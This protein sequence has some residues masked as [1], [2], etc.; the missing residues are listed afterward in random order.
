M[1]TTTTTRRTR[2]AAAA[3][4]VKANVNATGFIPSSAKLAG[5]LNALKPF[6]DKQGNIPDLASIRIE[7]DGETKKITLAACDR[8]V[9]GEYT[10]DYEGGSFTADVHSSNVATLVTFLKTPWH[11]QP[12]VVHYEPDADKDKPGRLV[13]AID[14]DSVSVPTEA[15]VNFPQW[16]ALYPD[17]KAQ[18]LEGRPAACDPDKLAKFMKVRLD[19]NDGPMR[20]HVV[21]DK[22]ITVTVGDYF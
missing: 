8:Y 1:T 21:K 2:K 4:V 7:A 10:F 6:T 18:G 22:P 12:I 13:V 19:K 14:K 15:G 9:L 20:L 16:K 17:A 11:S 5:A 3:P